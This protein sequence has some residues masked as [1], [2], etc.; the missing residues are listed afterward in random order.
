MIQL[1]LPPY[2]LVLD[3]PLRVAFY[4]CNIP[5]EILYDPFSV[6]ALLSHHYSLMA[7]IRRVMYLPIY[8][9]S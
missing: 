8:S 3:V 4:N 5:F 6:E 2:K 1:R 9:D 7:D